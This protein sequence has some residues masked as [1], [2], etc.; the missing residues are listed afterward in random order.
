MAGSPVA[1]SPDLKVPNRE[2]SGSP[3]LAATAASVENN[4]KTW[5]DKYQK[6]HDIISL[7][8]QY[9]KSK[10]SSQCILFRQFDYRDDITGNM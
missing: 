10:C 3:T 2:S 9:L 5:A 7:S 1:E 6:E 4:I 8:D